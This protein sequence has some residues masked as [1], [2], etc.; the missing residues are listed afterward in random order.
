MR[1]RRTRRQTFSDFLKGGFYPVSTYLLPLFSALAIPLCFPEMAYCAW[2][3]VTRKVCIGHEL[4][5]KPIDLRALSIVTRLAKPLLPQIQLLKKQLFQESIAAA[6][7][8][9]DQQLPKDAP[10]SLP[11]L[12]HRIAPLIDVGAHDAAMVRTVSRRRALRLSA[13]AYIAADF[14]DWVCSPHMSTSA[15]AWMRALAL[16]AALFTALPALS[17]ERVALVIGNAS[18]AEAPSL[19]LPRKCHPN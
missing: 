4:K 18:Y 17:A 16:V 13:D 7:F 2:H 3:R 5:V 8:Q 15:F 1:L 12:A 19:Y 10:V 11:C 6:F 9:L 14:W